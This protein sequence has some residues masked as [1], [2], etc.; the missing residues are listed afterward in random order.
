MVNLI[1]RKDFMA[2]SETVLKAIIDPKL[3][4]ALLYPGR[5]GNFQRYR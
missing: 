4:R 1:Y 3:A 5:I 2:K